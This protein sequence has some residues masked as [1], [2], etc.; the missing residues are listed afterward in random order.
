MLTGDTPKIELEFGD[1][2]FFEEK[3]KA[4]ALRKTLGEILHRN[5]IAP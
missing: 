5:L 3:G 1:V 4:E 2:G